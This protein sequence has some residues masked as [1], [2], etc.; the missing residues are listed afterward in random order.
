[1]RPSKLRS[2]NSGGWKKR[3]R[4]GQNNG[5]PAA[6][7]KSAS[8]RGEIGK[9]A[10]AAAAANN[11]A[12]RRPRQTRNCAS[13]GGGGGTKLRRPITH[14]ARGPATAAWP[15]RS[16]AIILAF[17]CAIREITELF[18]TDIVRRR[19]RAD[20]FARP[21]TGSRVPA[22]NLHYA[23]GEV[24]RQVPP[25]PEKV[26]V[27]E[28]FVGRRAC[29]P[30]RVCLFSDAFAPLFIVYVLFSRRVSLRSRL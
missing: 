26:Q 8:G 13:K 17:E 6:K 25:P 30:L 1:M 15:E 28:S 29:F 5:P 2:K 19:A 27:L 10:L 20:T 3:R 22:L 9:N 4:L 23:S 14:N 16:C 7:F 21:E 12:S 24:A 11:D 18:R